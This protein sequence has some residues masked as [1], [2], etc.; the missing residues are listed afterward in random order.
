VRGVYFATHFHNFY[1]EAPVEE[2]ERYVEELGLWGFN[3]VAVWFD[4]HHFQGFDSPEALVFLARLKAILQAARGVGLEASL[5]VVA[6]EGFADSPDEIGA[7]VSGMRG[8]SR[9]PDICTALP[10]GRRYVFE[11]FTRLFDSL[12]EVRPRY[13]WIWPY[14]SGGCGC[15]QCRPWGTRGFLDVAEP[16]AR[17]ARDRLEGTQ[18]VLSTW[19]F[20]NDEWAEFERIFAQREPWFD[21]LMAEEHRIAACPL[22]GAVP[23][24]GFLEISMLATFPWGGFGATP[25]TGRA[26]TQWDQ[27]RH[28]S[29]GG[30]LYSE[31]IYEDLTKAVYSQLYWDDRDVHDTLREYVAFHYSPEVVDEVLQVIAVLERNH[32][33]RWWPG[34]LEGVTLAENW[35]PSHGT[36][37]EEDPDAELASAIVRRVDAQLPAAARHSWRWRI[38]YL[39]AL[40]D[41]ELKG[42]GGTPNEA[43][44][45]AFRELIKIYHAQNAE[46]HVR[47]PLP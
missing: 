39:R 2:I 16:L 3:T 43:C 5:V 11:N 20:D 35:F 1:H 27:E 34:K 4:M 32:R 45:K 31:G 12:A 22:P 47:P 46:T 18:V 9:I 13:L 7:D 36:R 23:V 26:R 28:I 40:L 24:V 6:N 25:L 17:L 41:A 30:F 19:F 8:A 14:D 33:Y 42:N 29:S 15:A 38:L 21:Y 37:P 44:Y 10:E